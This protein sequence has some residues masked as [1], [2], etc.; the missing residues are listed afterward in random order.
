MATRDP[1][2]D[3]Y[4]AKSNE[5]ARPILEFIRD[6]VHTAVPD[7]TET[8]KWG[9]PFFE[10]KGIL[11][12]MAAFKAHCGIHFWNATAIKGEKTA[13]WDRIESLDDLPSKK[14]LVAIVKKA[15]K[16]NEEG[17]KPARKP[18]SKRPPF[19]VPPELSDA[20]AKN[21]KAKV[22]FEAFPP[23]HQREYAEWIGEAKR[24]ETREK[25]VAQAV[26]WIAEG[27][28]RNWKYER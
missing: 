23:S 28:S 5:F 19:E 25:R 11:C 15:A 7:V 21:K 26:E 13:H 9:M 1:R 27:K 17:V 8:I 22:A 6:A 20:L 3:A 18:P 16:L 4:I 12:Q 10:Y 2:V 14:D 24:A